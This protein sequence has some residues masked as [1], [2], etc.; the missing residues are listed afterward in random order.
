MTDEKPS[1]AKNRL[2]SRLVVGTLDTTISQPDALGVEQHGGDQ[3]LGDPV[4]AGVGTDPELLDRR[5][6]RTG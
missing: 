2:A 5:A 3:R 6:R 4:P 1:R